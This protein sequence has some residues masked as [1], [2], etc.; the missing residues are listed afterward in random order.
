[1]DRK[2]HIHFFPHDSSRVRLIAFSRPVGLAILFTAAPLCLLGFWLTLS[3]VLHESPARHRERQ[4][5]ERENHAL[6]DKAS[7]LQHDADALTGNLDS[8]ESA[9]IQAIQATGLETP[10]VHPSETHTLRFPF[11]GS[12]SSERK[13][14]TKSLDQDLQQVQGAS[15]FFDSSLFVL[16]RNRTLAEHFPTAYPVGPGAL[17]IRP[18]GFNP[19]PFTGR[20]GM[21]NGVDFSQVAGAPV[22]ASGSG[23]VIGAGQDP[24]W[25]YFVRIRHTDRVETFYAHLQQIRVH[26]GDNVAR[27]EVIGWIGQTGSA[28]G[29]HLHFEMLFMGE[30]VDPLQYLL[31]AENQIAQGSAP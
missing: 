13:V 2:I 28:T 29:P 22:F 9:R 5:L 8:L 17:V 11:F 4:R 18:F 30:H 16:S 27:G 10:E 7:V 26:A 21:H 31:P 25:G 3:G 24:L 14:T 6:S 15:L 1:M 12:G 19:D 23:S 20:R